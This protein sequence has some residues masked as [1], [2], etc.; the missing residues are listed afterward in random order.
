MVSYEPCEQFYN[1][2]FTLAYNW[3]DTEV[4]RVSLNERVDANGNV[5]FESNLTPQRIRTIEENIPNHRLTL[6]TQK[7]FE[8]LSTLVRVNF[9]SGFYE[10]HLD[11][12]AGLDIIAGSEFTIDVEF[13]IPFSTQSSLSFGAKNLLN[14]TPDANPFSGVAGA[15]YPLTSPISINGAFYYLRASHTF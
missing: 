11:A 3:T 2:H 7:Q 9:F 1:A 10:D 15:P 5:S 13:T 6:T 12:S 8:Y 4:A 14:N